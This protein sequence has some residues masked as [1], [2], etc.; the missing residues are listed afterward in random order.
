MNGFNFKKMHIVSEEA[1]IEFRKKK[2][3]TLTTGY[4]SIANDK[5]ITN[6]L[7]PMI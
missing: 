6:R 7:L 5:H 2:K 1:F 4:N 3:S